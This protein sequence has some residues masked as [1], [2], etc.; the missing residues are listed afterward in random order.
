MF[1]KFEQMFA[2]LFFFAGWFLLKV[3]SEN[4]ALLVIFTTFHINMAV[5]LTAF[6]CSNITGVSWQDWPEWCFISTMCWLVVD[7]EKVEAARL[8]KF[9]SAR[10]HFMNIFGIKV[11]IQ[12]TITF[13]KVHMATFHWQLGTAEAAFQAYR[14]K[15]RDFIIDIRVLKIIR[16]CFYKNDF[17]EVLQY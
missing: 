8:T 4:I 9:Y 12:Q 15:P 2:Y 5:V 14:A 3:C 11:F 10:R 7:I 13:D 16:D 17:A 6:W 1:A